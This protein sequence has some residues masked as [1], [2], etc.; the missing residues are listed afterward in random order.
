MTETNLSVSRPQ[1]ETLS[2]VPGFSSKVCNGD[3]K[4]GHTA[5][6]CGDE[7]AAPKTQRPDLAVMG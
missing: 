5:Y 6:S 2:L 3:G 7:Y 4:A 1:R